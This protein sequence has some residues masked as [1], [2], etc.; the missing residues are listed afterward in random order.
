M[1]RLLPIV[2]LFSIF[3][4]KFSFSYAQEVLAPLSSAMRPSIAKSIDTMV[5]ELPFFEDFADYEG[6]PDAKK[7]LTF[8]A[9]VNKDYAPLAPTIGM[10][11]L[12]ALDANGNLYPQASSN[13]FSADTLASQVIRL[14]SLTGTYQRRLQPSDSIYLSF[15]YQPGGWYGNQWELVGDAPSNQDSLFLEFYDANEQK[16]LTVWS[17]PGYDADTSGTTSHWPWRFANIRIDEQRFF[18]KSF[19]FR[20]RNYASLD[21]NPKSG[22]AGNCDQWNLDYIYLNYNRTIGDSTFRDVAFAEKAP[23]MLKHYHA[24]PA[25][26]YTASEMAS[27]LNMKIVNRY[28]QTLASNYSYK[29]FDTA[30]NQIAQYDGGFENVVSFFPNGH[31]QEMAVHSTPPVNFAF[32][33]SAT[34]RTYE[35]VH[36]VREGVGGDVHNGNDTTRFVQVFGDYY[37]YDDGVAENGYGLTATGSKMWLAYRFDLNTSDTLTAVDLCFNRTR[38]N[39]NEEIRFK[40]CVWTCQNGLPST[41]LYKDEEKMTPQFNGRNG[42]CRYRLSQPVIV[43]DTVFVGFE[44][45]SNEYINLGFDRSTDSRRYTFYRTGNEWMQSILSGSVMM[46]PAFGESALV[47]VPTRLAESNIRVFPNPARD[48]IQLVTQQSVS[49]EARLTLYDIQGR[50]IWTRQFDNTIDVSGLTNG[51]YVLRLYDCAT[52]L[53]ATEKII[54]RR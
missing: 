31:F 8:Q 22:I 40:L 42:F 47:S 19:Q 11:T 52:G 35:I 7:W 54:I 44:Q 12:D 15:F 24:M 16:W 32:A 14:D 36:V 9:Y 53:Q 46:R 50:H 43:D 27:A 34:P 25:R 10:A 51:V 41:L 48:R 3:N 20:F 49:S 1:R 18:N 21:P 39:E 28:N 33:E 45:L 26:Q 2:I 6:L 13:L 30:G 17:M 5:L 38:N 29:V 4:F 23:S 37:A